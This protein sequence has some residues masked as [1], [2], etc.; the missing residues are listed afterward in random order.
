MVKRLQSKASKIDEAQYLLFL[1][2]YANVFKSGCYR[3][4][5]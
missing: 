5:E 3:L 4:T 2:N 1:F